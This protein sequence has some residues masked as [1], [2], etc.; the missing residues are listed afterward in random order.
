M[1]F[2]GVD[3]VVS[4]GYYRAATVGPWTAEKGESGWSLTA[5]V[6]E[7][8]TFRVSQRPLTFVAS[9]A[10]GAWRWP[11]E[12]LEIQGASLSAMLGPRG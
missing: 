7:M 11:I 5:T 3:G 6:T 12:S 9:H 2:S 4:W 8:D 10:K 1:T